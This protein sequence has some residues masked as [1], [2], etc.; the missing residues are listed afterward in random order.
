MLN[1]GLSKYFSTVNF[2]T[3]INVAIKEYSVIISNINVAMM[4]MCKLT[5]LV[6]VMRKSRVGNLSQGEAP[7]HLLVEYRPI[8]DKEY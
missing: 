8:F 7:T 1:L 3:V 6:L 5:W 2:F 4:I